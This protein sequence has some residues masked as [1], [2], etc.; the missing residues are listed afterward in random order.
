MRGCYYSKVRRCYKMISALPY[1]P[2]DD[3]LPALQQLRVLIPSD[4]STF[5]AYFEYTW[6]TSCSSD[7]L[8]SIP[9]W[10]QYDASL[11]RLARSTNLAE[12]WQLAPCL[13][14]FAILFSTLNL[15][16]RIYQKQRNKHLI[17]SMGYKTTKL[18][19]MIYLCVITAS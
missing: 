4:L 2:D 1:L 10:N 11:M 6:V 14:L 19:L 7:P 13:Y 12:G 9:T 5:T 8:F 17:F 18:I 16:P 15:S 3:V